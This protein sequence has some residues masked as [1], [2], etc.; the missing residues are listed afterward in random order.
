MHAWIMY[1]YME[2]GFKFGWIMAIENF[3]NF[4][5][6]PFYFNTIFWLCSEFSKKGWHQYNFFKEKIVI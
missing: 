3:K 2:R 4:I 1:R 5:N 6:L